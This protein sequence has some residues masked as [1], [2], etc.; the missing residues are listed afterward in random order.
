MGL[1]GL[2]ISVLIVILSAG[3][4]F[5]QPDKSII[6]VSNEEKAPQIEMNADGLSQAQALIEGAKDIKETAEQNV[7]EQVKEAEAPTLVPY[8]NTEPEEKQPFL[9]SSIATQFGV[10]QGDIAPS[11]KTDPWNFDWKRLK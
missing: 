8:W 10:G 6:T 1:I 4:Y 7:E 3:Y 11:R 2:L 5:F 9:K